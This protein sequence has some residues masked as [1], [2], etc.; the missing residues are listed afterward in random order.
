MA[1][2]FVRFVLKS[3]VERPARRAGPARL[4]DVLA[5]SADPLLARL[6]RASTQSHLGT[7]RHIVGIE[8]WGAQRLR[9]ALGDVPFVLDEH[10]PYLPPEGAPKEALLEQAR[11]TRAETTA[12]A[13][14]VAAEGKGDVLV[15]HNGLGPLSASGWLRYLTMHADLEARRIR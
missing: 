1:P 4:A 5:S 14:R 12:V 8:R 13:R 9:V 3:L 11:S 7:I 2:P 6:Q 15:E 10:H